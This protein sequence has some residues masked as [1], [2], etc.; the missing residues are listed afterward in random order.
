MYADAQMDEW[1]PK[2]RRLCWLVRQSP[3]FDSSHWAECSR[4]DFQIRYSFHAMLLLLLCDDDVK[5][6]RN[7]AKSND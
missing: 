3:S 5:L 7:I 1:N 6:E 2:W 4:T